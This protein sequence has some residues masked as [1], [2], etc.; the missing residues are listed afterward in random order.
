MN[1]SARP[2]HEYQPTIIESGFLISRLVVQIEFLKTELKRCWIDFKTDPAGFIKR[3]RHDA[4]QR[5][6]KLLSTPHAIPAG[7]TAVVAIT[8]VVMLVV[9][10]D[11]SGVLRP[12]PGDSNEAPELVM[13]DLSP[14]QETSRD[15]SIGL[16]GPGRVGFRSAKGEGSGPTP[17]RA[18]GGG[19][20]GDR[21]PLPAQVGKIPP[22]SNIT[23][24][25]AP[26]I[27]SPALPVAGV[28]IDP[29][30]WKDLKAPVYGDPR[31]TS[32]TPS[33]GPGE[34]GSF[35]SN[36][37]TGFGEGVGPGV[38]PGQNGNMGG[39][40]RQTGCCGEGGGTG[41]GFDPDRTFTGTEVDQR[42]RLL[43]KPEPQY[44]EEARRNQITG[45]VMLRVIF[46]SAGAVE[47]I[48]A[49]RTLPFGLTEKAIAAARQIK[50]A[51][52]IKGGRP[53]SVHMQLEYNFNLY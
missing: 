50:F 20:S 17:Q 48:R 19:G 12:K 38:G 6:K 22:A 16:N 37:G 42:A 14:T 51:P 31:S 39:G 36:K 13:L 11:R 25:I 10:I 45:T 7:L 2:I 47:Q 23:A 33:K 52:A 1:S 41:N 29:A 9:L 3:C 24:A 40:A 30:L 4:F 34:G 27:N 35:G 46:S 18:R 44:T 5:L 53:V 49:V 8:S 32:E 21:N 26:H 15:S 43:F 28:D